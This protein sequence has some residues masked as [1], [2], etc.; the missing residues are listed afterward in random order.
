M[1]ARS[2]HLTPLATVMLSAAL[3]VSGC[4][5]RTAGYPPLASVSG[6]VTLGGVPLPEVNVYVRATG[7]G[8]TAMGLTDSKGRFEMR[9]SEVASGAAVGPSVVSFAPLPGAERSPKELSRTFDVD[10]QQGK[11]TFEFELKNAP[12]TN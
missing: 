9:Y 1:S 8:R 6:T 3:T 7:G 10:V 11:N 2:V 12:K 5:G 4:S